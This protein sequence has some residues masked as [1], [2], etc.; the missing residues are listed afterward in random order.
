V[1]NETVTERFAPAHGEALSLCLQS[2]G[3]GGQAAAVGGPHRKKKNKI[4]NK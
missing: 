3:G 4:K 1:P 2:L